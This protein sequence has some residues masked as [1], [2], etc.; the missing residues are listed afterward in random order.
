MQNII[1]IIFIV[2]LLIIT[3]EVLAGIW[4]GDFIFSL[5]S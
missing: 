5:S 2:G 4:I 1:I 3:K